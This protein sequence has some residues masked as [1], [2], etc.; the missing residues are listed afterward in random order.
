M[1][2][3]IDHKKVE[4][5]PDEWQLYQNICKSYDSET[6]KGSLLFEDLFETDNDGI[7]VFLKPPTNK[8]STLQVFLFL[9]SLMQQQHLRLMHQQVNDLCT[10]LNQKFGDK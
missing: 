3:I 6:F 9:S 5:T 1:I 4:M 8:H 7:I 10:K 2:K